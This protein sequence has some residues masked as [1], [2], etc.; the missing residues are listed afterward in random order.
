MH[1]YKKRLR[2]LYNFRLREHKQEWGHTGYSRQV[3]HHHHHYYHAAA[4]WRCSWNNLLF[5]VLHAVS[6]PLV[7]YE[8]KGT[9]SKEQVNDYTLTAWD[10]RATPV[11]PW[12]AASI[13]T[14]FLLQKNST[15]V[16]RCVY[17]S[18]K[19]WLEY[20]CKSIYFSRSKQYF[21]YV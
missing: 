6:R 12:G 11:S 13:C 1:T 7:R 19:L 2:T 17:I 15:Y 10:L 9:G 20:L 3:R 5:S 18:L 21:R 8:Q 14:L 16:M 4:Q